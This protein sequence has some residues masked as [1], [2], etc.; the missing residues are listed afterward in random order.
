M[1]ILDDPM[2]D[3]FWEL[4]LH[5]SLAYCIMFTAGNGE[6]ARKAFEEGLRI[7][8]TIGDPFFHF[9]LLS[10]LHMYHRRR[11]EL[12]RLLDIA[13]QAEALAPDLGEPT[14][15]VAAN[16]MLGV[17]HHLTGD[18]AAARAA[19]SASQELRPDAYRFATNYLGFHQ[20]GKVIL[21]RT[22]WLQGF[23][24]QAIALLQQAE[25]EERGD[26]VTAC[27]TLIWATTVL[28]WTGEWGRPKPISR[29]SS[30][31]PA[32]TPCSHTGRWNRLQG[33]ADGETGRCIGRSAFAARVA[34]GPALGSLR[35]LRAMADLHGGRRR[36]PR[37]ANSTWRWRS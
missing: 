21:A 20:D 12:D 11:G 5:S 26:P 34:G 8:R 13:R 22:L 27:L 7:S 31:W 33:R 32:R 25:A 4:N 14:A 28:I 6:R 35:A 2:R 29:V 18:L 1:A 19:L 23:P 9:R 15:I 30:R 16:V 10:N 37:S 17:S 36:W 3:T 24:D